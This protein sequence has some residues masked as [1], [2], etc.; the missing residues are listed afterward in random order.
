M[1]RGSL[2]AATQNAYRGPA[3]STRQAAVH[4]TLPSGELASV[5][6]YSAVDVAADPDLGQ[7]LLSDDPAHALNAVQVGD[8]VVA[9]ATPVVYHDPGRELMVLVLGDGDRHRELSERARLLTEMAADPSTPVPRYAREF[10]VVFGPRGLRRFLEDQ[11]AREVA[12]A[13]TAEAEREVERERAQL[14]R[15]RADMAAHAAELDNVHH[16]LDRRT[17]ELDRRAAELEAAR[18]ELEAARAELD[19]A[20][21]EIERLHD[22]LPTGR[23]A[24]LAPAEPPLAPDEETAVGPPPSLPPGVDPV[25][26]VTADAAPPTGW[27]PRRR[28]RRSPP[29]SAASG[30]RSGCRP[31]PRRRSRAAPWTCACSCTAPRTTRS[32]R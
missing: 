32:S 31:R 13:R 20:R 29:M 25:E 16:D 7:R 8:D 1:A 24:P 12:A 17:A 22:P 23:Q 21:A 4:V 18:A 2:R 27:S 19:A 10:Q 5:Q 11:A 28:R 30:W 6:V 3:G 26:T 15:R 9:I 14:E